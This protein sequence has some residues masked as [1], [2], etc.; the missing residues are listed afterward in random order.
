MNTDTYKAKV[1]DYRV[2]VERLAPVARILDTCVM[3]DFP[4]VE[5]MTVITQQDLPT[6]SRWARET[7]L[8]NLSKLGRG[9]MTVDDE[10]VARWWKYERTP[11]AHS[12]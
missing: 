10:T 2:Q 4:D 11:S 8:D 5:G 7:F 6:R 9:G 3:H 1:N 12:T